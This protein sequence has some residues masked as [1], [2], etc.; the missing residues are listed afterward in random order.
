MD[1]RDATMALEARAAGFELDDPAHAARVRISTR[2]LAEALEGEA[3]E[4]RARAVIALA[5]ALKVNVKI[6]SVDP[7]CQS[8]ECNELAALRV[9]WP[10]QTRD[11][12]RACTDRAL[13]VAQAM[14]FSVQ[15]GAI[16]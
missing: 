13:R 7:I 3:Y 4:Q 2:A 5:V 8:R 16:K 9:Y 15:V 14:S 11:L 1:E 12:C 10:G 6:L